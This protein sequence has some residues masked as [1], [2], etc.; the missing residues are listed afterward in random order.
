[1]DCALISGEKSDWKG[2]SLALISLKLGFYGTARLR[3][4]NARVRSEMNYGSYDLR[5]EQWE[6]FKPGCGQF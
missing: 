1:M 5:K 2:S 3:R 6:T 4:L